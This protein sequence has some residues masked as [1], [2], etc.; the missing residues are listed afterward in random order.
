[1]PIVEIPA[2]LTPL[3]QSKLT[4]KKISLIFRHF[5]SEKL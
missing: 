4:P 5:G 3:R 2:K 1:M